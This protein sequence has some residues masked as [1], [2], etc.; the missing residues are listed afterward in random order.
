MDSDPNNKNVLNLF[1]DRKEK[2]NATIIW[3][4]ENIN[5][6]KETTVKSIH[7]KFGMLSV[8]Y[9]LNID[10]IF[11]MGSAFNIKRE[12]LEAF[13]KYEIDFQEVPSD[14]KHKADMDIQRK[15]Y[16]ILNEKYREHHVLI[17][18]SSDKD[19]AD[20][21]IDLRE[22]PLHKSILIHFKHANSML[23]ESADVAI[24][25]NDFIQ[26]PKTIDESDSKTN[27]N[28][29]GYSS[30]EFDSDNAAINYGCRIQ[31]YASGIVEKF[32]VPGSLSL[33]VGYVVE[34]E[35]S[36]NDKLRSYLGK[37]ISTYALPKYMEYKKISKNITLLAKSESK[38]RSQQQQA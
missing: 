9:Y 27:L 7:D 11:V 30:D 24:S 20:A 26:K 38:Y 28:D 25:W 12:H 22:N 6:P 8:K 2:P 17:L 1:P 29:S 33:K 36:N 31:F 14:K 18:I 32:A 15:I 3:D 10:D 21:L 4:I 13:V 34:V 37:V 5:I 16:K 35:Y 19:F 23:I